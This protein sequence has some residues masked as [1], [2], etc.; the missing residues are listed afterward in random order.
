M[1][2]ADLRTGL[3]A[4]L[5][6]DLGIEMLDGMIDAPAGIPRRDLG[7]VWI[8]GYGE[9]DDRVQTQVIDVRV[10]IYKQKVERRSVEQAVDPQPLEDLAERAELA[11][12]DKQAAQYGVW[13]FRIRRTEIDLESQGIEIELTAWRTN[14]FTAGG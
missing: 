1:S 9:M 7:C 10:R 5:A 8:A 14:P 12:R 2:L 3:R 11:L 13:Y 6:T 4:E